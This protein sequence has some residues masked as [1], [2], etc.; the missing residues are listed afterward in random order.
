MDDSNEHILV[1]RPGDLPARLTAML[2]EDAGPR[3][4]LFWLALDT[5]SAIEELGER[6]PEPEIDHVEEGFALCDAVMRIARSSMTL[7]DILD[8]WSDP[9]YPP[10]YQVGF[11]AGDPEAVLRELQAMAV[12]VHPIGE[13]LGSVALAE[14]TDEDGELVD[15]RLL[16][17]WIRDEGV[18]LQTIEPV[19]PGLY[20]LGIP[21]YAFSE[22]ALFDDRGRG[23]ELPAPR[24][25]ELLALRL[26]PVPR[27]P[28]RERPGSLPVADDLAAAAAIVNEVYA[29]PVTREVPEGTLTTTLN[30]E[31]RGDGTFVARLEHY[32]NG[33]FSHRCE[34]E[35]QLLP[36]GWVFDPARYRALI[37]GVRHAFRVRDAPETYNP[38]TL[39]PVELLEVAYLATEDDF[40]RVA[41][42]LEPIARLRAPAVVGDLL[43]RHGLPP[44][45]A[46]TAMELWFLLPDTVVERDTMERTRDAAALLSVKPG[47]ERLLELACEE[48][49]ERLLLDGPG[50]FWWDSLFVEMKDVLATP[51]PVEGL[52]AAGK[53][54]VARHRTRH[55]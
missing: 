8:P 36:R 33:S 26:E 42:D 4:C 10:A 5:G 41:F 21:P 22:I 46:Q 17:R 47:G 34:Q 23:V 24:G 37:S 49:Y 51:L 54:A 2:P 28:A 7:V 15:G 52:I 35:V 50:A 31:H 9:M 16:L 11:H 44:V 18:G 29:E 45:D 43:A 30:V 12:E 39:L 14:V 55:R 48:W 6:L 32:E 13:L 3:R 38:Y 27:P 53:R 1:Y 25:G 19:V 40:A 20:A